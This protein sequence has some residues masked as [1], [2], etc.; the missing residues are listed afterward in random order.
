MRFAGVFLLLAGFGLT[1]AALYLLQGAGMRAGFVGCGV[2][3]EV[4]GLGVL[5]RGQMELRS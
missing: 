4:L 3:V 1:V 5:V 2:G